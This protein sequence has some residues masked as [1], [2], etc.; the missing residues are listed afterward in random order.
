[1][2]RLALGVIRL[3]Q[4]TASRV[5]P[6]ACRFQP[7]CSNYTLE[8]IKKYGFARG[9]WMGAKRIIRCNPFS[10]GGYDPVP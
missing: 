7:T 1:M 6:H 8:A 10:E 2:T 3:Y 5:L 4:N 9:S